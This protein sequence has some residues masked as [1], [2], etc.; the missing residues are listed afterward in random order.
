MTLKR[1]TQEGTEFTTV[2][3]LR[4]AGGEFMPQP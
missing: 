4:V 3:V 1:V 2:G